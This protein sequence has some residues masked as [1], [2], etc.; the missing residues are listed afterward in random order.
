MSHGRRPC[1][2]SCARRQRACRAP[3]LQTATPTQTR[4]H[5]LQ[6]LGPGAADATWVLGINGTPLQRTVLSSGTRRGASPWTDAVAGGAAGSAPSASSTRRAA[7]HS[8]SCYPSARPGAGSTCRAPTRWSSTTPTP[9]PRTRSRRVRRV[10]RA[11]Q[12]LGRGVWRDARRPCR[13]PGRLCSGAMGCAAL[14]PCSC[15][16]H[17]EALS[18]CHTLGRAKSSQERPRALRRGSDSGPAASPGYRLR[19]PAALRPAELASGG[20]HPLNSSEG[21]TWMVTN[22]AP[23]LQPPAERGLSRACR[24]GHRELAPHRA[25]PGGLSGV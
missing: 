16:V 25:D 10:Q 19:T 1:A 21:Y 24:A 9:T 17:I 6:C 12:G 7:R 22:A 2:R 20:A 13:P 8:S 14:R 3:R 11:P 23:V 18:L 4:T 5:G 15:T